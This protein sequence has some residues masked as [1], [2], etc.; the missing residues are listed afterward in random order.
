MK[1]KKEKRKELEEKIYYIKKLDFSPLLNHVHFMSKHYEV[2][3]G[4]AYL[5]WTMM[6][7]SCY[8][9][10]TYPTMMTFRWLICITFH[11]KWMLL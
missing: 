3:I 1:R 10:I 9:S 5:P 8:T 7:H 4:R 2:N 6:I 11:T